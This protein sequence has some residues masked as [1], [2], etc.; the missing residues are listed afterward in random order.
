MQYKI[1]TITFDG[2][3]SSVFSIFSCLCLAWDLL[4]ALFLNL[5]EEPHLSVHVFGLSDGIY[6]NVCSTLDDVN[7]MAKMVK[8]MERKKETLLL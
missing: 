5:D 2:L 7:N 4:V 8:A 1:R 3:L 6:K